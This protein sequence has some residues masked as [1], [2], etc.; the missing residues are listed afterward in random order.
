MVKTILSRN[1]YRPTSIC[2]PKPPSSSTAHYW[3]FGHGVAIKNFINYLEEIEN[4]LYDISNQMREHAHTAN[5]DE[6]EW[7]FARWLILKI[8]S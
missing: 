2:T 1:G 4:L 8:L 5:C 7:N 3:F 6:K